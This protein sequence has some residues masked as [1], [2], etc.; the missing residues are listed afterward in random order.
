MKNEE[1]RIPLSPQDR[2]YNPRI[3]TFKTTHE[4]KLELKMQIKST[5]II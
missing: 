1:T 5:Q 3:P 2:V 4:E